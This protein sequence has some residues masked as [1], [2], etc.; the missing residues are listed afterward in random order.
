MQLCWS[1]SVS[2]SVW[3]QRPHVVM[4]GTYPSDCALLPFI[5]HKMTLHKNKNWACWCAPLQH[6]PP[7]KELQL[8][9]LGV[10]ICI[11]EVRGSEP[12]NTSVL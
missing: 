11:E 6:T 7:I 3:R 9:M 4:V 5:C 2:G 8:A 1:F 10:G 12:G